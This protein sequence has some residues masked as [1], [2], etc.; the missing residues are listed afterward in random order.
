MFSLLHGT[1]REALEKANAHAQLQAVLGTPIGAGPWYNATVGLAHGG[2]IANC[3]LTLS[4]SQRSTDVSMRVW[5]QTR[6]LKR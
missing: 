1:C 6:T 4:G 3:T 5:A 2:R